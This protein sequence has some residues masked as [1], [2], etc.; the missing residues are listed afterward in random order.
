MFQWPLASG[1]VCG[2]T[3]LLEFDHVTPRAAGGPSTVDNC[4]ILCGPHN[5]LAA[6]QFYGDDWMDRFTR[7]T[8]AVGG[9]GGRRR[10]R[11]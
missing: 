3:H 1:G 4:R 10:G 11:R 7:S 8:R 5:L 2:A 6:R 9:G